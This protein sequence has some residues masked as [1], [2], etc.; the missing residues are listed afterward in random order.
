AVSARGVTAMGSRV[1]HDWVLAPLAQ[2]QAIEERLDAVAELIGEQTLRQELRALL[3]EVSDLQRLTARVSTGRVS[4]RDLGAVARTLRLLPRL[5]AKVTARRAG[6]LRE[7]EG[8]LELCQD[9]REALDAALVDAP[10]Q[11]PREGGI[12]RRGYHAALDAEHEIARTGKEWI[13][14]FQAREVTRTGIGSLKVGFN[15]V[16][17]YYIEI[18]HTH[19]NKIP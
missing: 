15:K 12:I 18:T 10:P 3:E 16:F 11:S 1:L 4:P 6:L 13:A 14:Q 2:R 8:R 5:K 9:L 7:L 17:G 19:A